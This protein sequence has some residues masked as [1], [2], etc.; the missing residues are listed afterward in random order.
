MKIIGL[1]DF[2]GEKISF[3]IL[4]Q[5]MNVD[6][7]KINQISTTKFILLCMSDQIT[8]CAYW[9]FTIEYC[10]LCLTCLLFL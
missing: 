10:R 4:K 6:F 5:N 1:F 3:E 2:N 9:L 7:L 8:S